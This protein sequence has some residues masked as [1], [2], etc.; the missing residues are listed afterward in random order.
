MYFYVEERYKKPVKVLVAQSYLTFC[1][2]WTVACQ[3][4]LSMNFSRQEYWSGLSSLP[5]GSLPDPGM[6][7]R[8]SAL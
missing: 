5:P 4:P 8:S 6:K 7:P 3:D 2:P 1:I